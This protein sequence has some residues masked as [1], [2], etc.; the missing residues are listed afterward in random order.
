[1]QKKGWN[2]S[3]HN[4]SNTHRDSHQG[5]GLLHEL[6]HCYIDYLGK[7]IITCISLTQ[8]LLHTLLHRLLKQNNHHLHITYITWHYDVFNT[9]W[10]S[11]QGQGLLHTLL[12]RLLGQ[13]NHHLHITY[14]RSV[15]Y[16]VT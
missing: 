8:G 3:R 6:L 1:M 13:K 11:H 12:H 4:E 10:D 14:T 5:Q 7:T 9:H 15:T 16:I 2:T